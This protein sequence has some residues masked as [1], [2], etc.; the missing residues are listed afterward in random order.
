LETPDLRRNA[1]R[2]SEQ[3][4][5]HGDDLSSDKYSKAP[6]ALNRRQE[7]LNQQQQQQQQQTRRIQKPLPPVPG[8]FDAAEDMKK[9]S[10]AAEWQRQQD[11]SNRQAVPQPTSCACPNNISPITSGGVTYTNR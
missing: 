5:L 1:E 6:V 9:D 10:E 3:L 4:V 7:P 11:K 2:V 8:I